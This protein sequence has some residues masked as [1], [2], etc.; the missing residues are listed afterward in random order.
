MTESSKEIIKEWSVNLMKNEEIKM[1][2]EEKQIRNIENEKEINKEEV[3]SQNEIEWDAAVDAF[4]DE[5]K[6]YMNKM[7]NL[8]KNKKVVW[9]LRIIGFIIIAAIVYW[10][11]SSYL[12]LFN[13]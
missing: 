11:G 10:I 5:V 4:G 12:K 3:K 1:E 13:I 8:S 9:V 6:D 7:E 2:N